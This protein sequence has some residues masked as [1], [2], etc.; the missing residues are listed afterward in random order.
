MVKNLQIVT[1]VIQVLRDLGHLKGK[2][3]SADE[4]LE[5][6]KPIFNDTQDRGSCVH[7]LTRG[8]RKGEECGKQCLKGSEFCSR[9]KKM[10]EEKEEEEE[11]ELY[12]TKILVRGE[13]KDEECGNKVRKGHK[14]RCTKHSKKHWRP[15]QTEEDKEE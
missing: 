7:I 11:D 13:R 6:S 8:D 3:P 2:V 12:C 10:N 9:H 5:R 4:V 14:C 1:A 15:T